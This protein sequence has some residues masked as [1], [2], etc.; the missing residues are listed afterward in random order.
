MPTV[1][2]S[3]PMSWSPAASSSLPTTAD[4]PRVMLIPW[5]ASPIAASSCVRYSLFAS[6]SAAKARTQATTSSWVT[7]T[8]ACST[9]AG[10]P[11]AISSRAPS[12]T[13]GLDGGVPQ[14]RQLLVELQQRDR[15]A[16]HLERG[17]VRPDQVA[18]DLDPAAV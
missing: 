8:R 15:A 4:M 16:G 12:E 17:D 1:F 7:L 9:V 2:S 3:A 13:R 11:S 6:T 5:S 10:A 14:A 18:G